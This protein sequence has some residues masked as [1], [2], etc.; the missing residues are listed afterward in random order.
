MQ[1]ELFRGAHERVKGVSVYGSF[2]TVDASKVESPSDLARSRDRGTHPWTVY[3]L[4]HL[5]LLKGAPF[6]HGVMTKSGF[7][8]SL[9]L[10][11]DCRR[12]SAV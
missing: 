4:L 3:V 2:S 12:F 10:P 8:F 1:S 11:S 9:R 5:P 7:D 6:G